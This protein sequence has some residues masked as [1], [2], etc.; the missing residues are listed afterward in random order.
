MEKGRLVLEPE[1]GICPM[2][3]EVR[4]AATDI[5]VR[6]KIHWQ[7]SPSG[8]WTEPPQTPNVL[9]SWSEESEKELEKSLAKN[10]DFGSNP[11]WNSKSP[12]GLNRPRESPSIVEPSLQLN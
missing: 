2:L 8:P 4:N 3:Q 11:Q 7:L 5:S 9:S 6:D 1:V 10:L 12:R